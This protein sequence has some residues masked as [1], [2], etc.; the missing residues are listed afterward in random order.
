MKKLFTL[1]LA[2]V[3]GMAM[4]VNARAI[5]D[6]DPVGSITVGGHVGLYPGIGAN[7][8]G[9]YVLIDS[10]WKGHFTVGAQLA[11]NHYDYSVK[12]G[13]MGYV[14]TSHYSTKRACL[15]PRATYG[16]NILPQLEVHAGVLAGL[17]YVTNDVVITDESGT[18]LPTTTEDGNGIRLV[19]GNIL[20]ARYFF[21]DNLAASLELNYSNYM[22]YLNV[23]VAYKF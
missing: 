4:S 14:L 16:L 5:E 18:V 3:V 2:A 11:Y 7:V 17:G 1:I 6:Q 13:A 21:T 9:D 22:P 23:G 15:V 19:Y 12:S 8:F 20:G 10:W